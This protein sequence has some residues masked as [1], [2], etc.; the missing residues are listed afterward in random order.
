[1]PKTRLGVIRNPMLEVMKIES[2]FPK[3]N[4]N[5][6]EECKKSSSTRNKSKARKNVYVE[7]NVDDCEQLINVHLYDNKAKKESGRLRKF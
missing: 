6:T 4:Q 2:I 3:S 5:R 7:E 1:M